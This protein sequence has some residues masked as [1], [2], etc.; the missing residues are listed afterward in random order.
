MSGSGG[1]LRRLLRA[2]HYMIDVRRGK[3]WRHFPLA[4]KTI[5]EARKAA[6]GTGWDIRF[7]RIK[8]PS[9]EVLSD[10]QL[11]AIEREALSS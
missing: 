7:V 5:A 3:V 4:F 11:K 9:R 1:S 10:A 6:E 8:G 2:S